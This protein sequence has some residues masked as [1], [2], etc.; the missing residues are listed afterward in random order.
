MRERD[1]PIPSDE[2]LY[3]WIAVGDLNGDEVL[4]H[5]IDL[6]ETSVNRAKYWPE[7]LK[8]E[9]LKPAM[10]GLATIC[11]DRFPQELV[12]N[13]VEYEFFTVDCP[14]N[15]NDAHAEIR[16]GRRPT[17][18]RPTGDRPNGY[19]PKSRAAKDTI[20]SALAERMTLFLRPTAVQ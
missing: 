8:S 19:K 17:S 12:V 6:A 10:N 9:P 1:E 15:N 20:R 7:P 16:S 13:D 5:A 11:G 3:R 4:P 14:E 2:T 18:E